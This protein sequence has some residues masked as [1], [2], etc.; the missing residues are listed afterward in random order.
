MTSV[1]AGS[2]AQTAGAK[3]GGKRGGTAASKAI[4]SEKIANLGAAH[5]TALRVVA[6]ARRVLQDF[7]KHLI[8]GGEATGE[9]MQAV[10]Q[11]V[12]TVPACMVG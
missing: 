8:N 6:S 7:E 3:D 2:T 10:G 12:A 9:A 5:Q 1:I 4:R 11:V